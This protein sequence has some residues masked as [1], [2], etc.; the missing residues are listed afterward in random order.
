MSN[1]EQVKRVEGVSG[2]SGCLVEPDSDPGVKILHGTVQI[3]LSCR[4][5]NMIMVGHENNVMDKKVIFFM[6]FLECLEE[7]A[8]DLSLIESECS[9]V[10]PADQ[11]VR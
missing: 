6:G 10:S 8:G 11:V 4:G 9:V 2:A 1:R 3:L 7:N 5:D